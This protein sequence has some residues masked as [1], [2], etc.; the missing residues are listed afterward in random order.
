MADWAVT[1]DNSVLSMS[2]AYALPPLDSL[3]KRSAKRTRD[4]F[5]SCPN[6]GMKEDEK[7]CVTS[8]GMPSTFAEEIF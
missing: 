6:D 4:I 3:L 1:A 8:S 2:T 7:R 5:A